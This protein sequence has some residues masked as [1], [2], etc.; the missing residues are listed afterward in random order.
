ME[1]NAA[2]VRE[3]EANPAG[4]GVQNNGL[5][6]MFER[7]APSGQGTQVLP[8]SISPSGQIRPVSVGITGTSVANIRGR[9]RRVTMMALGSMMTKAT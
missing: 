2:G 4:Q 7:N 9:I 6:V 1:L 8:F 5:D 3:V